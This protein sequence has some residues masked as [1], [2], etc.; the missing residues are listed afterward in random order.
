M[1]AR[2]RRTIGGRGAARVGSRRSSRGGR[3]V[4]ER[5]IFNTLSLFWYFLNYIDCFKII[6]IYIQHLKHLDFI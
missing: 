6:N 3:A 1:R 4:K 2:W 5:Y